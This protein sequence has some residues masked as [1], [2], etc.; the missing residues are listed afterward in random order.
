M[1]W[2]DTTELTWQ[3]YLCIGLS[4]LIRWHL[5]KDL[6]RVKG[7]ARASYV[8]I[9]KNSKCKGPEAGAG[10]VESRSI[11]EASVSRIEWA[12]GERGGRRQ[13]QKGS[14]G[15]DCIESDTHHGEDFGFDPEKDGSHWRIM[16]RGGMW[17]DLWFSKI[18]QADVWRIDWREG[19]GETECPERRLWWKPG[20]EVILT[21][22]R[23]VAAKVASG[24]ILGVFGRY[25]PA[26]QLLIYPLSNIVR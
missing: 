9:K 25:S 13:G 18:P 26:E 11:K 10:L 19:M 5:S 2:E 8:V 12:R 14:R 4:S 3:C 1:F 6:D 17:S 22:T 23:V 16:S 20:W 7:S 24:W 21:W 15:L